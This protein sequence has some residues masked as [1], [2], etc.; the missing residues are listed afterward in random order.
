MIRSLKCE[1]G[2]FVA[3]VYWNWAAGARKHPGISLDQFLWGVVPPWRLPDPVGL[4]KAGCDYPGDVVKEH[5]SDPF[6]NW[7]VPVDYVENEYI[8]CGGKCDQE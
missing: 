4:L 2:V 7:D 5:N 1:N 6:G 8:D 3:I